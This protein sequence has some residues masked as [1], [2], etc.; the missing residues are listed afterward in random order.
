[1][2]PR[3][4]FLP[5][6]HAGKG[7]EKRGKRAWSSAVSSFLLPP[8]PRNRPLWDSSPPLFFFFF[9]LLVLD[10]QIPHFSPPPS[11][12]SD[13]SPLSLFSFPLQCQKGIVIGWRE[14]IVPSS[15]HVSPK[16]SPCMLC[17]LFFF[18]LAFLPLWPARFAEWR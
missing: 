15:S 17:L 2:K 11:P 10:S 9:L 1:M 14:A 5:F 3:S 16:K 12:P 7:P 18:F 6:P 4:P 13:R 8:L